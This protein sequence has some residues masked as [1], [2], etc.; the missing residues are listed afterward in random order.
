M[1]LL[2]AIFAVNPQGI[3]WARGVMLT[4]VALVPLVLVTLLAGLALAFGA[5]RVGCQ[6]GP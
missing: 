5:H 3:N 4:D 1:N 6:H 2:A